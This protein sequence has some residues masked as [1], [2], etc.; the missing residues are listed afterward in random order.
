MNFL[1]TMVLDKTEAQAK[2]TK[3]DK[4]DV[5][6][7]IFLKKA[8][9]AFSVALVGLLGIAAVAQEAPVVAKQTPALRSVIEPSFIKGSIVHGSADAPVTVIEYASLT[10]SHC[11][12]FAEEVTGKLEEKLIPEGKVRLEFRNFVR[13]RLDMAVSVAIRC[14]SD[15]GVSKRLLKA[16][17][18]KQVAWMTSEDPRTII[19]AIAG[20]EGVTEEDLNKCFAS[21]SVVQHLIEMGQNASTTYEINATPTVLMDGK[22]VAFSSYANLVEQI[23]AA[24]SATEK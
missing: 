20:T 23:E 8:G 5:Y 21:K 10:C 7:V 22:K 6:I 12:T 4:W 13:D 19:T 1:A 9:L 17:F 2:M 24:V 18:T 14:T 11:K 15:A 16:Y 3:L